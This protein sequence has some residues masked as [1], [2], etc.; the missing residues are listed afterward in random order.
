MPEA[1]VEAGK[2]AVHAAAVELALDPTPEAAPQARAALRR[3]LTSTT[4]AGRIDDAQLALSELVTNAVL[5]G[6]RPIVVLLRLT[7]VGLRVEVQDGSPL[8]PTFSLLDPTAVTGRGL[9]LISALSDRWGVEA[10]EG[11]K[12]VWFEVEAD[13]SDDRVETDVDALLASWG[14]DLDGDPALEQVRVILTDLDTQQ[15]ARSEAHVEALL[16]ELRLIAG[17]ARAPAEQVRTAVAVL[18]AAAELDAVRAGLRHQLSVAL[19]AQQELVDLTLTL[20]REDAD[21]VRDFAHALDAA[22]RL[23]RK[24]GLLIAPTPVELSDVRRAYLQRVVSQLLS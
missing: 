14:D 24:G 10:R 13:G 20:R 15:V 8:S 23:T 12:S 2:A 4:L 17:A 5:H 7:V 11:G 1:T 22:D 16:R 6:R 21:L 18:Q 3:L 9:L 19:A